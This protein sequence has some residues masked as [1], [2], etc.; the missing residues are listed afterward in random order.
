MLSPETG[1]Q[2][3]SPSSYSAS[4]PAVRIAVR[5]VI[6]R[7]IPFSSALHI[8]RETLPLSVRVSFLRNV[9]KFDFEY[10]NKSI[11]AQWRKLIDSKSVKKV[12]L[13]KK[14]RGT[15]CAVKVL[16]TYRDVVLNTVLMQGA[17]IEMD[18]DR[19]LDLANMRFVELL[20]E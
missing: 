16:Q 11:I 13:P 7:S 3:P 6:S 18:S 9:P 17:V 14:P 2:F 5:S 10:D 19:A 15:R 20:E 12:E 8:P 1:I 4:A